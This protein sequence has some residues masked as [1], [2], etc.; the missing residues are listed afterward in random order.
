ME[1]RD[2]YGSSRPPVNRRR[3]ACLLDLARARGAR[4]RK[5][6]AGRAGAMPIDKRV[7]SC[8]EALA[9]V[10]DGA[11]VFISGF[12][13]AGFPNPLVPALAE[14]APQDL[15]LLLHSPLLPVSLTHPLIHAG[16]AY[17]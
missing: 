4:W 14:R 2:S 16:L 8:A 10:A 9:D 7:N 5:Q 17:H 12:G 13:G 3:Q 1:E 6:N 11:T 15:T